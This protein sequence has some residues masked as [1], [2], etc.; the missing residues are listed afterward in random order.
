MNPTQAIEQARKEIMALLKEGIPENFRRYV[1]QAPKR[2]PVAFGAEMP[3]QEDPWQVHGYGPGDARP[4]YVVT[5]SGK[6]VNGVVKM[7]LHQVELFNRPDYARATI[8]DRISASDPP[9]SR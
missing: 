5:I 1:W 7:E 4:Y 9:P 8:W 3:S 2:Q 6:R